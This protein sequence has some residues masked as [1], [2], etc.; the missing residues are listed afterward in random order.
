MKPLRFAS[1]AL[2]LS[3]LCSTV[4][5]CY[6]AANF[7]RERHV[8]VTEIGCSTCQHSTACCPTDNPKDLPKDQ[9]KERPKTLSAVPTSSEEPP[10]TL[11][12]LPK[13]ER[14]P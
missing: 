7:G 3:A 12:P 2:S 1:L 5:C 13:L 10:R 9:P 8:G 14:L 4:G 6:H 11:T